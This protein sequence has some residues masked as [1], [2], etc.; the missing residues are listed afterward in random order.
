MN[1]VA[2]ITSVVAVGLLVAWA[3]SAERGSPSSARLDGGSPVDSEMNAAMEE[4]GRALGAAFEEQD[5][6]NQKNPYLRLRDPCILVSRHE[7]E[8][9][10]GRLAADPYRIDEEGKPTGS[11]KN[12]LYIAADGRS[13]VVSP[14]YSGGKAAMKIVGV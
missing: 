11:G 5:K 10:L 12:C 3:S 13:I 2:R 7:A 1:G 8:Q 4:M 9:F 14:L 6:E